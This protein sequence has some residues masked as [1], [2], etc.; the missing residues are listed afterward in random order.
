MAEVMRPETVDQV[1]EAVR[2]ALSERAP[3]AVRGAGTKEAFGRPV[4]A[5]HAL[6]TAALS[7]IRLHEP[8]ELVLAAGSGTPVAEVEAALA[9][10]GQMLAFE[11]PDLGPLWGALPAAGTLGGLVAGNL[12]GPRRLRAGAARDH[13]LGLEAV[14]GRGELFKT[15]GRVVKNVTGYDL[16]KVMTGAWGTL[17]VMGA[18]TFKVLPAPEVARTLVIAGLDAAGALAAMT[19]ALN[20]PYEVSGAAWLPADLAARTPAGEAAG[21]G[22]SAT[23]LRL[24]GFRASVEARTETLEA[25]LAETGTPPT[26]RLDGEASAAVWQAVRDAAPFRPAEGV[27]P[28]AAPAVWRLSVPPTAG[29]E[30]AARL[31]AEAGAEVFLDWGG[32]LVWAAV[33]AGRDDAGAAKVRAIVAET[34]KSGHATLIRAPAPVRAAVP[35]F[36]PQPDPLAALSRRVKQSFDPEGVLNPGRMVAGV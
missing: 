15:G 19:R 2:W 29:P 36:Q 1:I 30:V 27:E 4:Q 22:A 23:L 21:R 3:L 9:A 31:E 16:C 32:G 34:A 20:G 14:N 24:E 7:G 13:L 11:P 18:L 25:I 28:D 12:S 35:V 10:K 33:P 5:E 26:G 17:G 6:S 8:E